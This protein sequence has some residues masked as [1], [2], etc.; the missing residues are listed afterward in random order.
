MKNSVPNSQ[1]SH[2]AEKAIK[3]SKPGPLTTKSLLDHIHRSAAAI[4]LS[5]VYRKGRLGKFGDHSKYSAQPHPKD[6]S[7]PTQCDRTSYTCNIAR[8]HSG[9]QRGAQCLIRSYPLG[10]LWRTE[11]LEKFS[12]CQRK[13]P[14]LSKVCTNAQIC[15][16]P[17]DH[18]QSRYAPHHTVEAR[19]KLLHSASIRKKAAS[20]EAAFVLFPTCPDLRP[21]AHR[22]LLSVT[23]DGG[24]HKLRRFEDL[25]LFGSPVIHIFH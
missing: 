18:H 12:H 19:Y 21:E 2:H 20:N 25:V 15:P 23:H 8:S 14:Q 7:R 4:P 11:L 16:N 6:A 10:I 1:C 17:Q 3:L 24:L 5:V 9:C 22:C 13:K